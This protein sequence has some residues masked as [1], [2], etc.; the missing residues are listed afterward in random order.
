MEH[1]ALSP[2]Q[3]LTCFLLPRFGTRH[4]ANHH[5]LACHVEDHID[6]DRENMIAVPTLKQSLPHELLGYDR[7]NLDLLAANINGDI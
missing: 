1:P 2:I 4:R 7:P 3:E 5:L 6:F